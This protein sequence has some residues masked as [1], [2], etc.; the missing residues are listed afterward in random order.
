MRAIPSFSIDVAPSKLKLYF[1][2]SIHVLA[3]ISILLI[4]YSG[5]FVFILKISL[6]AYLFINLLYHLAANKSTYTL[7][8][9]PDN[10]IDLNVD[11]SVYQDL[12]LSRDS[13]IS[14]SVMQLNFLAEDAVAPI[15]LT[16][17]PDSI[18]SASCSQLKLRLT[19]LSS[20]IE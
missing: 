4:D 14:R 1:L 6:A 5:S 11:Q 16:L 15:Y 17:F 9:K 8:F 20:Q 3:G 7:H 13:Y 2:V 12:Q 18:D 19:L 10:L